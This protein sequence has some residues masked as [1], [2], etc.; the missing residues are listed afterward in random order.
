M[1]KS[2][3]RVAFFEGKHIRKAIHEDEWWFSIIDI[4]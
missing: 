3:L 4:I 1:T 2:E